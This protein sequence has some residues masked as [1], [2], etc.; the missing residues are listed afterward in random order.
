MAPVERIM[1]TTIT[2]DNNTTTFVLNGRLDSNSAPQFEQQLQEII[3]A[4]NTHLV[5]DCNNLEY[6]SSAG[7]RIILNVAKAYK[8]GGFLFST[9][10]MQEHVQEVFEISGFD[11]FITIHPS[12]DA[13]LAAV[14]NQK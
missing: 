3:S 1:K 5:F 9:C 8:A 12:I 10:A 13:S 4:P 2:K 14:K 11:S 7:L 6:I